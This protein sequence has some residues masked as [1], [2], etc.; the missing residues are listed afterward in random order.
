MSFA[1]SRILSRDPVEFGRQDEIALGEAVDLVGVDGDLYFAPGKQEI[2]VMT[3][4]FGYLARQVD[5][6]ER[7]LKIRKPENP[8][9]MMV[10]RHI[11]FGNLGVKRFDRFGLKGWDAATARYAGLIG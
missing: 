8:V 10:I 2:G 6:I 9:E 11:P 7:L 1:A 3:L 4:F 5:E